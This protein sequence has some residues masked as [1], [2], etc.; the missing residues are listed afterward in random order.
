MFEVFA[1]PN[2]RFRFM[3]I[4][5]QSEH[6]R[7][8]NIHNAG[9]AIVLGWSRDGRCIHVR[10][11][12]RQSKTSYHHSFYEECSKEEVEIAVKM[13]SDMMRQ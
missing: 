7:E 10:K 3:Q 12:G 4:V 2:R 11:I 6:A 13:N 9:F 5:K 1:P 8:R